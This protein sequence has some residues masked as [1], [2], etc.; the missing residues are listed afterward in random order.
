MGVALNLLS[1]VLKY[2]LCQIWLKYWLSCFKK[3]FKFR[4]FFLLFRNYLPLEKGGA[5]HL[6]K[7]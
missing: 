5:L 1:Q 7:N 6:K 3:I 2:A 4:Q